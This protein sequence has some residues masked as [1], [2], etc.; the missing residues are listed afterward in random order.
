LRPPI[1]VGGDVDGT[2][3]VRFGAGGGDAH[4]FPLA[5]CR[6][7]E[8]SA[9]QVKGTGAAIRKFARSSRR[10]LNLK[11]APGEISAERW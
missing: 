4:H 7:V 1:S 11:F 2:E 5:P 3:A 8:R 9:R 10:L 6:L